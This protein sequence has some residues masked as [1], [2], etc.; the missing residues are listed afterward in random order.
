MA[1]HES[2]YSH[3]HAFAPAFREPP[4]PSPPLT[5]VSHLDV[6]MLLPTNFEGCSQARED[7]RLS[8]SRYSFALQQ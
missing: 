2:L 4:L 1:P 8:V 6:A 3:S 7:N 5:Y